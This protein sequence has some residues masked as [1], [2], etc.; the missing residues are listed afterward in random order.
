[1]IAIVLTQ[2]ATPIFLN[3]RNQQ[4]PPLLAHDSQVRVPSIVTA[5]HALHFTTRI[6]FVQQTSSSPSFRLFQHTLS[7]LPFGHELYLFTLS[8]SS[9]YFFFSHQHHY[10]LPLNHHCTFSQHHCCI[11]ITVIIIV[12]LLLLSSSSPLHNLNFTHVG[13]HT[14]HT[15]ILTHIHTF[16]HSHLHFHTH[17]HISPSFN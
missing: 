16:T 9:L 1:M 10:F 13:T 14:R 17:F 11:T 5:T 12:G 6:Q 7:S 15:E 4:I 2:G 3:Q 8:L